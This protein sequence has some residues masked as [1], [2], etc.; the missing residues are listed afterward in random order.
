MPKAITIHEYLKGKL[1]EKGM[2]LDHIV[3]KASFSRST[4]YRVI[5]GYQKPSD[6]FLIEIVDLLNLNIFE[7]RELQYYSTLTNADGEKASTREEISNFIYLPEQAKREP[8][9]MIFMDNEKFILTLEE[10]LSRLLLLPSFQCEIHLVN[11]CK[12]EIIEPFAAFITKLNQSGIDYEAEHFIEFSATHDKDTI[13]TL[14]RVL[15]VLC[16]E[17]YNVYYRTMGSVER[18]GLFYDVVFL[19]YQYTEDG[20]TK[21]KYMVMSFASNGF[22][23]CIVSERPMTGDFIRRNMDSVRNQYTLLTNTAARTK[24]LNESFF[25]LEKTCDKYLFKPN[26][27][28][29]RIPIIAY[30][31]MLGRTDET[32]VQAFATAYTQEEVKKENAMEVMAQQAQLMMER[33]QASY[34]HKH[35]DI[36]T[37]SGLAEFAAT[38]RITDHIDGFPEFDGEEIAMSFEEIIRR[39]KDENDPYCFYIIDDSCYQVDFMIAVFAQYGLY[40]EHHHMKPEGEHAPYCFLKHEKL[41]GIF[42][43]F[44]ENYIPTMLAMAK[45]ESYEFLYQLLEKNG[46]H[47]ISQD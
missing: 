33:Q 4:V 12:N 16:F 37:K 17:K 7:Q 44:A 42:V 45:K 47:R 41:S 19:D 26:L 18:E 25:E 14:A 35:I 11:C 38:G 46:I 6:E 1:K 13:V 27:C 28:Y 34:S 3:E 20:K 31:H 2:K 40:I 22:S 29:D 10:V 23:T 36:M 39:D 8:L 21:S 9:E 24:T 15:P 32:Q 30:M 43:D 5:N